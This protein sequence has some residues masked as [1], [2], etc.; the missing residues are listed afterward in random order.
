MKS[1]PD[2]LYT[3]DA[4]GATETTPYTETHAPD[5]WLRFCVTKDFKFELLPDICPK[6]RVALVVDGVELWV[7]GAK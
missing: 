7:G 2:T 5:G 1:N 4:C 6:H 3:C